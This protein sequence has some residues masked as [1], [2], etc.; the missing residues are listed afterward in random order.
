MAAAAIF[1][2][3][4]LYENPL[5]DIDDLRLMRSLFGCVNQAITTT[6]NFMDLSYPTK[7]TALHN[8]GKLCPSSQLNA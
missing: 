1:R 8:Y 4:A 5:L 3:T 7:R 2:V 6:Q